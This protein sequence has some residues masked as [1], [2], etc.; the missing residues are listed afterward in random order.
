M[1]TIFSNLP[2]L[3][4]FIS[5]QPI[6]VFLNKTRRR[7]IQIS[8]YSRE[9]S[10]AQGSVA[11]LYRIYARDI[12]PQEDVEVA[13]FRTSDAVVEMSASCAVQL[14]RLTRLDSLADNKN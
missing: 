13:A 4:P 7:K 8:S 2:A 10:A 14:G 12:L 3:L 11:H 6:E 1:D 5:V 9:C